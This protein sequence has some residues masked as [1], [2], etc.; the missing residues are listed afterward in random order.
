ME[1]ETA[2]QRG[3]KYAR[4]NRTIVGSSVL[5]GT[6]QRPYVE[7]N[8]QSHEPIYSVT[9]NEL[10]VVLKVSAEAGKVVQ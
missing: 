9:L 7:R 10:K 4:N 6:V 8:L 3:N 2:R 1:H 5:C